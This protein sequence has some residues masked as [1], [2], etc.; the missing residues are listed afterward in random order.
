MADVCTD[1]TDTTP[2]WVGWNARL[3]PRDDERQVVEY[4][5]QINQSPTSYPVVL[6]T[7]K[8]TQKLAEE[9]NKKSIVVTYDLA[10]A[11]IAMSIQ[12][13][14][15]PKFDN[16]FVAL[17][18]FHIELAFFSALGKIIDESGAPLFSL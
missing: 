11:K 7:L 9:S 8:R 14:E 4:L 17:G 2:M 3:I 10:I 13:E 16:V 1:T 18:S 15:F 6:E 12:A 5:K